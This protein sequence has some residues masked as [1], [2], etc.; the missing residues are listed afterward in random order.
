MPWHPSRWLYGL[1]LTVA[2][3]A[4]LAA[5][6]DTS[7]TVKPG[8]VLNIGVWKEPELQNNAVLVQPDGRFS[9]PLAGQVDAN[10]RTV[11]QLQQ[12]ISVRLAHFITD[13]VVTV[14]LAQINGNKV[15]VLGQVQKPGAFVVNP[16]VDVMQAISM[17]GGTTPFAALGSI[18]ILRRTAD[19]NQIALPFNYNDVAHG[20]DLAQDI[21]LQAGDVVVV[22]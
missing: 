22:P 13:P 14:S 19:G 1:L 16:S 3:V 6:P 8:D 11:A 4:A 17:A 15:Y 5:P 20:N 7:Y 18:K 2:S 9:F 12:Q 21:I 10:G